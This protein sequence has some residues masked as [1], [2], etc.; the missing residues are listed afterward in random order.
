MA[1]EDAAPSPSVLIG[2][3]TVS[4]P[5]GGGLGEDLGQMGF[6]AVMVLGEVREAI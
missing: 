3:V 5:S 4:P 2:H 6:M 1:K